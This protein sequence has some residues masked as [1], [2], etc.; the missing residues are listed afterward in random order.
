MSF[1]FAFKTS[2]EHLQDV[3]VSC[4]ACLGK[5]SLEHLVDVCKLGEGIGEPVQSCVVLEI[6]LKLHS[7]VVAAHV[8][9]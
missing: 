3:L 9:I 5:T 1:R 7:Q 2:F 4:L 6:R 8:P